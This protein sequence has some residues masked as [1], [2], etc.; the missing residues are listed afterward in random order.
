MPPDCEWCIGEGV[1]AEKDADPRGVGI[2]LLHH[3]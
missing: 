1:E 3:C 2:T